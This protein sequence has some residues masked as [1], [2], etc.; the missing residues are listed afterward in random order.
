VICFDQ[1][2]LAVAA[3]LGIV[4][5]IIYQPGTQNTN[6]FD[7]WYYRSIGVKGITISREVTLSDIVAIAECEPGIELSLVGH[8]HLP[9]FYSARHLISDYLQHRH[10]LLQ[11]IN[12]PT[13]RLE[14]DTRPGQLFPIW[15]DEAGTQVYRAKQLCSLRELGVLKPYLADL[16]LERAFVSD[17]EY[18]QTIGAYA[19]DSLVEEYLRTFGYHCDSGSLYER[20]DQP[21]GEVDE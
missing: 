12:D 10:Q 2:V 14:E 9:L 11:L 16:F 15:E 3:E 20:T 5:K 4:R 1:S 19:E 8:G 7:P 13:L 6:L 18:F 21:V 17:D